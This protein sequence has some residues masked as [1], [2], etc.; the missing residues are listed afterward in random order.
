MDT[1]VKVVGVP[2]FPYS[3]G[4]SWDELNIVTQ[5]AR[6][7]LT[8]LMPAP[9]DSYEY[10]SRALLLRVRLRNSL[11]HCGSFFRLVN[12]RRHIRLGNNP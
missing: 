12:A 5:P 10:E 8:Q 6:F 11:H 2:C 3:F 4:I 9:R 1:V 7:M